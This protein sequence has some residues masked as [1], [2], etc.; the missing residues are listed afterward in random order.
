MSFGRILV[1]VDDEPVA[2]HAAEVGME[3]AGALGAKLA[4]IYV[5]EPAQA[6]PAESGVP[7]GETL[8]H[9]QRDARRV[10]AALEQRRSPPLTQLQ[11]VPVGS[12]AQEIV[13]AAGEWPADLVVIGSHGRGGV[14]RALLG[15]VAE[16][17]T[18]H[19]PCPV[20]VVKP[21]G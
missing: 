14:S 16:S 9:A 6:V 19:A 4:L 3:L 5:V 11:F 17:V 21:R 10:L 18:R 15:S 13:R 1:A 2:A 7:A 8:A 20:L 12:A